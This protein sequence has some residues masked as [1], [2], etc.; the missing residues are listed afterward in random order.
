MIRR[1][2]LLHRLSDESL[3]AAGSGGAGSGGGGSGGAGS[4]GGG[5]AEPPLTSREDGAGDAEG[6]SGEED[7]AG[8][9]VFHEQKSNAETQAHEIAQVLERARRAS[10]APST[11]RSV[12]HTPDADRRGS[13]GSSAGTRRREHSGG[14]SGSESCTASGSETVRDG[15]AAAVGP[16][17][18]LVGAAAPAAD[19]ARAARERRGSDRVDSAVSSDGEASAPNQS[20]PAAHHGSGSRRGAAPASPRLALRGADTAGLQDGSKLRGWALLG[21]HSGDTHGAA[22]GEPGG[23]ISGRA[24]SRRERA[25]VPAP[26]AD[27]G[28]EAR[29]GMLAGEGRFEMTGWAALRGTSALLPAESSDGEASGAAARACSHL[30]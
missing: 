11:G 2:S 25:A 4:G 16:A 17:Q 6:S 7:S 27:Q 26:A 5:V 8:G 30:S 22:A 12:L 18:R 19:R 13:T 1:V 10:A 14:N 21:A 29:K 28:S 3:R 20:R 9:V 24:A 15:L 23:S